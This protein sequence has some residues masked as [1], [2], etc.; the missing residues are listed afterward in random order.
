MENSKEYST[1]ATL[2]VVLTKDDG[3]Q[4]KNLIIYRRIIGSLQYVTNTRP[5]LAYTI[6]KLRQ[7]LQNPTKKHMQTMKRVLRSPKGTK[8]FSL[9]IQ[10][11]SKY[12]ITGF[13]DADWACNKDD[14][15][16]ITRYCVYLDSTVVSY[17]SKKQ[18]MVT[19]S[20]TEF[21]YRD[22]A[23]VSYEISQMKSLLK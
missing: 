1:P 22:F 17:S 2:N 3:E 11:Y 15:R 19:R 4:L 10:P 8:N 18:Q 5:D 6:N 21:E 23:L 12:T 13:F 20:N 9:H 7:F 16:S 14:K